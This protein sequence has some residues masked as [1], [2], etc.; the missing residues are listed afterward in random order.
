MLSLAPRGQWINCVDRT[1]LCNVIFPAIVDRW[2]ILVAVSSM[3]Q[4]PTLS[5]TVRGWL[6]QRL[7]GIRKVGGFGRATARRN[8][9]ALTRC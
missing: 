5:R 1:D 9:G 2:P 7:P 8:Q 3:G 6:E 4:S